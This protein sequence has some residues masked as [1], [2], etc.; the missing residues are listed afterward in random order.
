MER[1]PALADFAVE[2][3]SVKHQNIEELLKFLSQFESL[4]DSKMAQSIEAEIL[5][6]FDAIGRKVRFTANAVQG[7]VFVSP[8]QKIADAQDDYLVDRLHTRILVCRNELKWDYD[9]ERVIVILKELKACPQKD[10]SPDV[11]LRAVTPNMPISPNAKSPEKVDNVHEEN[12]EDSRPLHLVLSKVGNRIVEY[13][14][15]G[16][17]NFTLMAEIQG[18]L[19]F[20]LR[21]E[22]KEAE[23][24]KA[25]VIG[26]DGKTYELAAF[27]EQPQSKEGMLLQFKVDG[28]TYNHKAEYQVTWRRPQDGIWEKQRWANEP[29]EIQAQAAPSNADNPPN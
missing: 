20:S 17:P 4:F 6:D 5:R 11:P 25:T 16:E 18:S 24:L 8:R 22:F 28:E 3:Q 14:K 23:I 27:G 10:D 29:P 1:R 13:N 2:I 19:N 15:G 21:G 12:G 9:F 7:E 26:P